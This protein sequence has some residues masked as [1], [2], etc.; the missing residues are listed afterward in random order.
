MELNTAGYRTYRDNYIDEGKEAL[1]ILPESFKPDFLLRN[2]SQVWDASNYASYTLDKWV[3][4]TLIERSLHEITIVNNSNS[5]TVIDVS[6]SYTIADEPATDASAIPRIVIPAGKAA[7]FYCA[8]I[9]RDN[10]LLFEMRTGSQDTRK[11]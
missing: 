7:Y 5:D 9:L 10:N 2:T 1:V 3:G 6:S 4:A 11:A 8:A